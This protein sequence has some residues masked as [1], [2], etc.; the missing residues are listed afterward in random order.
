[1]E[2][3]SSR[4]DDI[5]DLVLPQDPIQDLTQDNYLLGITAR[6]PKYI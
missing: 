2:A 4:Q 3:I 6:G 1:M 5:Q